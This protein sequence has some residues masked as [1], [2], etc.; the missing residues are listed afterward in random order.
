M[1]AILRSQTTRVLLV[2]ASIASSALVV[3]AGHRWK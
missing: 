3:E 2:L 1:K